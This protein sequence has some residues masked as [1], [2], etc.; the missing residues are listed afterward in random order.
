MMKKSKFTL[1]ELLIV[2]SIIAILAGLLLPALA[3]AR[4]K[5]TS[6]KCLSQLSAMMK[7]N[8]MYANNNDDYIVGYNHIYKQVIMGWG[9]QYQLL[10]ACDATTGTMFH[11]PA[12]RKYWKSP[13]DLGGY[14]STSYEWGRGNRWEWR[15][16]G[17]VGPLST[18]TKMV[19][20]AQPSKYYMIADLGGDTTDMGL[21]VSA[22]VHDLTYNVSFVDGHAANYKFLPGVNWKSR[23]Y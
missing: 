8:L 1:I 4:A 5:G 7:A 13:S 2:V 6:I 14:L 22:L 3:K 23:S 20:I 15:N 19:R 16:G 11:C 21:A 18:V 9:V 12:D 10:V 17:M